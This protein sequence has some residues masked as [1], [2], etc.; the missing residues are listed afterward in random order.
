LRLQVTV[1]P[2]FF[3]DMAEARQTA[4]A[5]AHIVVAQQVN[6]GV[7]PDGFYLFLFKEQ[8]SPYEVFYVEAAAGNGDVD[9]RM[10]IELLAVGVERAEDTHFDALLVCPA[11]HCAGGAVE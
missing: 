10:L 1:P 9:I 2:V 5:D 6:D 11:E 3:A 4:G 8:L 7:A